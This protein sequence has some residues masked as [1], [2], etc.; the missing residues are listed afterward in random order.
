M[1]QDA[2]GSAP[3]PGGGHPAALQPG[4]YRS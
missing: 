4:S 3:A 1:R 2:S